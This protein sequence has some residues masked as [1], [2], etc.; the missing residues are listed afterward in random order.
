MVINLPWICKKLHCKG[1]PY[2]FSSYQDP[3]LQTD[4]HPP[5]W[6]TNFKDG[7][8]DKNEYIL[9][10][11]NAIKSNKKS[12]VCDDVIHKYTKLLHRIILHA[13]NTQ[14]LANMCGSRRLNQNP[15]Q[16]GRGHWTVNYTGTQGFITTVFYL[17]PQNFY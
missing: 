3:S 9:G 10:Q 14:N 4:S 5:L 7:I 2:R 12:Q 6:V 16:G 15:I 11:H 17:L 8:L 13:K 1:E